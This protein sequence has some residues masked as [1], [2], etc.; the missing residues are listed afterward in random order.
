[1]GRSADVD[2]VIL[3]TIGTSLGYIIWK[4]LN[5]KSTSISLSKE[6]SNGKM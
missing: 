3:N 1:M 5:S 4:L 6:T 2:D